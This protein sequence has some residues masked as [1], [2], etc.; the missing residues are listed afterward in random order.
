MRRDIQS[1]ILL[2]FLTGMLYACG[3]A[4]E[5]N[6]GNSYVLMSR[7]NMAMTMAGNITIVGSDTM[8]ASLMDTTIQSIGVYRSGLSADYPEIDLKL[9]IDSAYLKS[10]MQKANDP[11]VPDVQK[12]AAVL[13]Y[14]GAMMLPANCYKFTPEVKIASGERVGNVSLVLYKSKFA[15]L[16]NTKIYLPVAMDTLSVSGFNRLKI[17]SMVQMVNGF[18]FQKM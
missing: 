10:L 9:K 18:K 11:A 4:I 14:K 17:I 1:A 12:P 3:P 2:L 8:Y 5:E 16:K 13:A 6:I 7:E 15:R